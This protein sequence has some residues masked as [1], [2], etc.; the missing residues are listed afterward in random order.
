M[1]SSSG[2]IRQV[3][4]LI[5]LIIA[6]EAIFFLP[7]VVPRIFRPTLLALFDINNTGLGRYFSVYGVVAMISYALGGPLAD[8]FPARNLMALALWLTSAGGLIMAG[9]PSPAVMLALYAFWGATTI[10]LFWAALIRATREWGGTGFQGRAFGWLE[11]GRGAIAATAGT[12][13]VV[14]FSWFTTAPTVAHD[15]A[16]GIQPLQVIILI[17]SGFTFLSGLL[18]WIFVPPGTVRGSE[19]ETIARTLQKVAYV[20]RKP[21]IWLLAVMIV[22]AYA[23]YKIT[24]DLSL[25]AREVLGFSETAAAGVGASA[26]WLR[27]LVAILAGVLADRLNGARVIIGAYALTLAGSLMIGAGIM[28][29]D[30]GITLLYLTLTAAGIYGV[31]ALYFAVLGEANIPVALTGTA[32]GIVSFIGFT[33]DIFMGPLMGYLLDSHPG[34]EGHQ[35]LFLTL[36]AFAL[37]GLIASIFFK[38]Y[39]RKRE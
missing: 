9:V 2:K 7:F 15:A 11:G 12:I 1:P 13:S 4:I 18:I 21:T 6:G 35:H 5:S 33:P 26:L 16:H 28:Q 39:T 37:T 23:G 14:L 38:R 19:K 22:C 25:Y 34:P 24:D 31:R 20:L 17:V 30:T 3:S 36:A 8:R 27:A 32:V 10:L 29:A